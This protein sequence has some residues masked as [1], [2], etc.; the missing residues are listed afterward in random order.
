MA[1]CATKARNPGEI[2]NLVTEALRIAVMVNS[3]FTMMRRSS[4]GHAG[5]ES[6]V[7]ATGYD[8]HGSSAVMTMGTMLVS[9]ASGGRYS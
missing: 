1:K 7:A 2:A 9:R 8:G 4:M 3:L 6:P 5:V